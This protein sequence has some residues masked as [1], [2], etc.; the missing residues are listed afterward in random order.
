[1]A[2]YPIRNLDSGGEERVEADMVVLMSGNVPNTEFAEA[3]AD[4]DGE[5]RVVGDALAPR[6]LEM[7]IHSGHYAALEV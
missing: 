5:V 6:W 4:Y 2:S 3:I 7:A 1:M